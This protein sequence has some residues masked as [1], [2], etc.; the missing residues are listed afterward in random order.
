MRKVASRSSQ[1]SKMFG[2]PASWHTVCSPSRFTRPVSS[3]YSGPI[4]AVV[5]IHSGLRSIGVCALRASTRSMR[6]PSGATDTM[7]PPDVAGA[8]RSQ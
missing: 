2:Q 7:R 3:R 5:R 8:D 1:H 6:R 4:R